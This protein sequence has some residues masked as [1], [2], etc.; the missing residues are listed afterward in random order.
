V[1]PSYIVL[2]FIVAALSTAPLRAAELRDMSTDRPDKTESAYTVDAG[3]F[4]LEMDIANYTRTRINDGTE[5]TKTES[6]GVAPFNFKYGLTDSIDLQV[7]VDTFTTQRTTDYVA[8]TRSTISGFGDITVRTKFNVWGNDGGQTALAVMPF[9]K[10]PTAANGLGNGK[11]EGGVIVPLAVELPHGF[12]LGLMT[13]VDLVHNGVDYRPEF[14]NSV[15]V[16]TDLTE[17]LGMYVEFFTARSTGAGA[18]WSN[19]ADVGF[20][21]ALTD[22][23]QLDAGVNLGVTQAADDVNTFVGISFRW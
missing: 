20:T 14:I 19:T 18:A 21:Y 15:T 4:Q 22:N 11:V 16:G 7:L 12:G 5:N 1:R 8:G 13:E 9:I 17:K 10:L 6:Y 2:S 3:H 23:I